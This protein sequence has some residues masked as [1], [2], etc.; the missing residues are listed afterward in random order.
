M[1]YASCRKNFDDV[2]E[3]SPMLDFRHGDYQPESPVG[4][5]SFLDRVLTVQVHGYNANFSN[6]VDAY[7]SNAE[8]MRECVFANELPLGFLWPGLGENPLESMLFHRAQ[9][10]ADRSAPHLVNLL[11]MLKTP[12]VVI[13]HSLGCRVSLQAAKAGA[14]MKALVLLGAAVDDDSLGNLYRD[15]AANVPQI[16]VYHSRRDE[17]LG[18]LYHLDQFFKKALG[19]F[20]PRSVLQWVESTDVTPTVASHN[21]YRHDRKMWRRVSKLLQ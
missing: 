10:M 6:V 21:E 5:Q 8:I 20:G 12:P 19:C 11:A 7:R 14:K 9:S 1:L 3:F 4:L 13:A 2:N 15:A 17:V 16:L 18:R